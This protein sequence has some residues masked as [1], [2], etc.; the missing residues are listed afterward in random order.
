M[1]VLR[2]GDTP[3]TVLANGYTQEIA[4]T[5]DGVRVQVTTQLDPLGC[6]SEWEP[7]A[8]QR[9][10]TSVGLPGALKDRL[11]AGM[12]QWS[13]ASEILRWVVT[14]IQYAD[15]EDGLQ[16]AASV[17][18]RRRGTCAGLANLSVALLHDAGF[19]ARTVSGLLIGESGPVPHRW[20]ECR[21]P[22]VGWVPSDPTL[23]LWV[24]TPQHLAYP[25][26]LRRMPDVEVVEVRDQALHTLAR[27]D[28]WL[29][30]ENRGAALVCHL[31]GGSTDD[32][33]FVLLGP[34]G[35]RRSH[36]GRRVTR[37]DGLRAGR[38]KLTVEVNGRRVEERL[39]NLQRGEM[40][41]IAI[42]LSGDGGST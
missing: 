17:L 4:V 24:V 1:Y 16:D 14:S 15:D 22:G 27:E 10:Q 35:Q 34:D 5:N 7:S 23:G 39:L 9:H 40:H 12:D 36:W 3:A 42:E 30:R 26:P 11:R 38:W 29:I 31:V 2:N 19:E 41:S 32:A 33:M 6:D 28:G 37:F 18:Q 8:T 21:L 25:H 20:L 13:V